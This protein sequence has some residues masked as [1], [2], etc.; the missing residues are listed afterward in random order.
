MSMTTTVS[1]SFARTVHDERQVG[2]AGQGRAGQGRAGMGN[3]NQ[4]GCISEGNEH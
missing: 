4:S 3:L 2:R 1:T